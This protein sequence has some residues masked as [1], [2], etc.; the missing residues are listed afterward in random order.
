MATNR[1]GDGPTYGLDEA[2]RRLQFLASS[3]IRTEI[4]RV[5]NERE[6][7]ERDLRDRLDAPRSTVHQNVEKLVE[8]GWIELGPEGY[9]TT[10]IGSVVLDEYESCA[11]NI[12]AAERLEPLLTHVDE[13]AVN[14]AALRDAEVTTSRPNRPNAA[15]TRLSDLLEG[16]SRVRLLTPYVIPR[17]INLVHEAVL[18]DDIALEAVVTASAGDALLRDQTE[19]MIAVVE[20]D[21][22]A[23]YRYDEA[24][25]FALAL[26]DDRAVVGA[27]DDQGHPRTVVETASR[28]G[29]EWAESV[30]RGYR[31]SATLVSDDDVRGGLPV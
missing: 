1:L 3:G 8:R 26:M 25:P 14:V 17:F 2:D 18:E 19:R 11:R 23:Y 28:T 29:T 20:H 21:A 16:T 22:V 13:S 12:E 30:Y 15:I 10:W 24:L 27:F 7:I 5:L 9:R 31:E 4:L 6:L